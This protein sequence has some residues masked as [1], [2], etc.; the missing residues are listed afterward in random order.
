MDQRP[1]LAHR[2]VFATLG[3][4][5]HERSLA[6]PFRG[7]TTFFKQPLKAARVQPNWSR[8]C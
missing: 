2:W 8:F 6:L 7:M 4:H 1:V 3:K 5:R